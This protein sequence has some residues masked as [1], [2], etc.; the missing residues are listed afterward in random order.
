M[1]S[2]SKV[3]YNITLPYGI[4]TTQIRLGFLIVRLA[5]T[6]LSRDL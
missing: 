3:H 4:A 1:F 6:F 5:H 2:S